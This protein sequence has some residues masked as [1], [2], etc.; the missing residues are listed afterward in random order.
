MSLEEIVDCF[1]LSGALLRGVIRS[2]TELPMD[3]QVTSLLV[4]MF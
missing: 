1:A 2:G 4:V 3:N